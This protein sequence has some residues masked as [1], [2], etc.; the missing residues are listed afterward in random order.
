MLPGKLANKTQKIKV[1]LGRR[2][3]ERT[4]MDSHRSRIVCFSKTNAFQKPIGN[5]PAVYELWSIL[6]QVIC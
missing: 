3:V 2:R 4:V 5:T 6:N 1:E